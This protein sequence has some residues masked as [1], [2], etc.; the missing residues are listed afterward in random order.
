MD[1]KF[2]FEVNLRERQRSLITVSIII[3]YDVRKNTNIHRV[4]LSVIF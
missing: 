1:L 3:I 4:F 2:E